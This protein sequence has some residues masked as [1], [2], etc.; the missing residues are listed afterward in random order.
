MTKAS[1]L[2][3]WRSVGHIDFYVNNAFIQPACASTGLWVFSC[4]HARSVQ[5]FTESILAQPNYNLSGIISDVTR[6][7]PGSCT[8][9]KFCPCHSL[10]A[11]QHGKC[12]SCEPEQ[13]QF[14][15]FWSFMKNGKGN[16]Y[17]ELKAEP[18]FCVEA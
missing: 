12:K 13:R 14:I 18:P 7:G 8:Y 4:S 9:S 5:I 17:G 15:G 16:F 11:F 10:H 1:R 2:G 3:I 6:N